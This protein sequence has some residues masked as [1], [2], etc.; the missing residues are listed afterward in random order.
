M[1][2]ILHRVENHD[3]RR[4]DQHGIGNANRVGVRR[5][6]FLHTAHNVVAEIAKYAGRHWR[7]TIWQLDPAL[8]YQRAQSL[9]WRLGAS[10]E[11]IGVGAG[12]A[13]DLG[14]RAVR[15]P[16]QIR[17]DPDDRIAAT[18]GTALHRL[19]QEAHCFAAAKLQKGGDG[20][21]KIGHQRGPHHLRLSAAVVVG[22][23]AFRRL[24]LHEIG[25]CC[26]P[27]PTT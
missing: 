19:E 21:L 14:L 26:D 8:R 2:E 13:I 3:D 24:N 18:H 12:R 15:A 25:Y 1:I 22:E 6:Q 9:Q 17:L 20:R 4:T 7:Q 5:C 16:D 23:D 10:D 27:P 11:C